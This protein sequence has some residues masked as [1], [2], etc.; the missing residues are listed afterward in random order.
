MKMSLAEINTLLAQD[1]TIV[2]K[3]PRLEG[4]VTRIVFEKNF[5]GLNIPV[6][7]EDVQYIGTKYASTGPSKISC[8]TTPLFVVKTG[9]KLY[10]I[11]NSKTAYLRSQK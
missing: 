5:Q 3:L 1:N 6:L 7:D 11:H 2:S 8:G 10:E 9:D 4:Q